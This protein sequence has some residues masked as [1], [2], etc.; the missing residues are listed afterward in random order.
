[1]LKFSPAGEVIGVWGGGPDPSPDPGKFDGPRGVAVDQAGNLA[2]S[3]RDN[4]RVQRLIAFPVP[5][6]LDEE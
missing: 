3:D 1:V 2:V 4:W 6:P 5:I